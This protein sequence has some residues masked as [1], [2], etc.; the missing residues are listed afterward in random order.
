[1]PGSHILMG[2]RCK[3]AGMDL[4]AGAKKGDHES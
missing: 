1:M 4:N 2:L 3:K